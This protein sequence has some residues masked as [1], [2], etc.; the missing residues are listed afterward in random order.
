[1]AENNL[2]NDSFEDF[3]PSKIQTKK[4]CRVGST[5][6]AVRKPL[7]D[8]SN[9]TSQ[10]LDG[11]GKTVSKRTCDT[12][13]QCVQESRE[14]GTQAGGI[15]QS[16]SYGKD[17][18]MTR[19]TYRR[20]LTEAIPNKEATLQFCFDIGL[21]PAQRSCPTCGANMTLMKD[22]KVSDG[23]RW[24]CRSR[25]SAKKHEHK[26]SLRTGT[27]FEKSNMT[28][29]EIIQIMYMWVHGH[30][31]KQIHHELGTAQHTDVDWSSF[32]REVCETTI[33]NSSE[34]IGGPGIVVEIDESKFAKRKYNVGHRVQGGWVF[35]GREKDNKRKVFMEPVENRTADTLL[36]VI[37][38][39]IA[40][41]SIIWSDCWK[42]YDR[43][44]SL[45]EGYSHYTVNH[46]KNFVDPQT[47]TCTNRIESD[48]RH[49][50]AV[51]PR[52]GTTTEMYQSYLAVFMWRRRNDSSDVDPFMSFLKDVVKLYPGKKN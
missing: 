10:C 12:G 47:G 34:K 3:M 11:I 26:L 8:L 5:S 7:G 18:E 1:M 30:S 50:K 19:W 40:P 27:F 42:S 20:L 35:G 16:C 14:C 9:S 48:W 49:A 32:C 15:S 4:K 24:Y 31:Q 33:I 29:E 39:W 21:I 36:A 43:I 22:S 52:F 6:N 28:L 23:H 51:C 13:I 25:K 37:Q 17:N 41:G 38:K 45:P 44:P 2:P 46:S